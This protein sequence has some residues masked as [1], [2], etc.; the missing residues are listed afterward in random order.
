MVQ[1]A[2]GTHKFSI[3]MRYHGDTRHYHSPQLCIPV[4]L[5]NS[6]NTLEAVRVSCNIVKPKVFEE[7]VFHDQILLKN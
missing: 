5:I 2:R 7:P 4:T 6:Q 1:M 3:V